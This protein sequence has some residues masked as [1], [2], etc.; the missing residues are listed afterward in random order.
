ML[1][2]LPQTQITPKGW[3]YKRLR[4]QADGLSGNIE[5]LFPDLSDNSAWL[6]GKGEAWERGVYYLDGLIP[7]A[8]LLKDAELIAKAGKWANAILAGKNSLFGFGPKRNN[9]YWPRFVAAKALISFYRATGD[10]RIIPFLTDYFKFVNDNIGKT[11]LFYWAKAR[12][13]EA[14]E[15]IYEVYNIAGEAFLIE[16]LEKL[17][18]HGYDWTEY[19]TDFRYPKPMTEYTNRAI[20]KLGKAI[21]EPFDNLRKASQKERKPAEREKTE[22]FNNNPLVKLIMLTHGVNIAMAYK[23]PVYEALIKGKESLTDA[24]YAGY[25]N[26][27]KNHGLCIGLHSSDEHIMGTDASGGVE[28]CTVTEALYSFEEILRH[29]SDMRFAELTEFIAFNALPAAFTPDMTAHQY[30]QQ[31]NQCSADRKNRQ[32]FDTDKEANIYG[33]A[34]NYGCCAANMHQGFPKFAENLVYTD[35]EKL[36]FYL[37]A[38]FSGEAQLK[39][40]RVKFTVETEYPFGDEINV[41]IE[42]GECRA[43]LRVPPFTESVSLNGNKLAAENTEELFMKCGDKATILC[44]NALSVKENPDGSISIRKNNLLFAMPVKYSERYVRGKRPF[45]YREFLPEEWFGFAPFTENGMIDV[46]KSETGKDKDFCGEPVAYTVKGSHIS[47]WHMKYNSAG[48][49]PSA[50]LK[51]KERYIKLVPYGCTILRISQFPKI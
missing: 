43:V 10:E 41:T 14:F 42:E 15:A 51:G 38:P 5:R 27:M 22:K 23:Y 8:Y 47:N 18:A 29:T 37:Y 24:A 3:L 21:A 11:G 28:L 26:I 48:S 2:K 30:V 44:K 39:N 49:P 6:G 25:E 4:A 7:L 33:I 13:L 1:K 36:Y 19:F 45:H 20:F 16:L 31:P 9:D 17:I 46:Y 50:A 35:G 40:G 32:F 12:S 34:P